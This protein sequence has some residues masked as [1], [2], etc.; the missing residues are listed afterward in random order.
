MVA[1]AALAV[2]VRADGVN[3]NDGLLHERGS[4]ST[5]GRVPRRLVTYSEHC[6]KR[7]GYCEGLTVRVN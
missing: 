3:R 4:E 5:T 7:N 2:G 1:V 6:E